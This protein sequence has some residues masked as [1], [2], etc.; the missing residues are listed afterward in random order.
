MNEVLHTKFGTAKINDGYYRIYSSK[1]GNLNKNLHRL[2]YESFYGVELPKEVVVHHKDGNKLNNCILN[3]EAMT[4]SEHT[5]LHMIGNTNSLG[6]KHREESKRKVSLAK[7]GVPR[8]DKLKKQ[9]S[10]KKNTTGYFRVSK[11]KRNNEQGFSWRY[12]VHDLGKEIVIE[13]MDLEKLKSKVIAR[14]YEWKKLE[15]I[16]NEIND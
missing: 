11:R 13:S 2:I 4:K 14:G 12:R 8:S 16:A 5:A 15:D 9:L 6:R 3:L 10:L 7:T 1:E